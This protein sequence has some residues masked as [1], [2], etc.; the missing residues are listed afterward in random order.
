M[1]VDPVVTEE[2]GNTPDTPKADGKEQA[3]DGPDP[4]DQVA[5][6]QLSDG[7]DMPPTLFDEDAI[8]G[9][10]GD[11][12]M[13]GSAQGDLLIANDGDDHVDGQ[14]GND[15]LYG[16][17]GTDTL[18]GQGGDDVLYGEDGDDD[19]AGGDGD[20][21]L[22]GGDGD[23]LLR[24]GDGDDRL[25]G[26]LGQDTVL[27]G[28]GD[29][30]LDGT[31]VDVPGEGDADTGD[32]LW[33][34]AG[35]DTLAGGQGDTLTGGAGSDLYLF[36]APSA[37]VFGSDLTDAP[38]AD[39]QDA[40]LI[41]DFDRTEDMLE[42]VYDAAY[43]PAPGQMPTVQIAATVEAIEVRLN[44]A[45]VVRLSPGTEISEGDIQLVPAA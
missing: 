19:L 30:I 32:V 28:Q 11:N 35:N 34:E 31:Q 38:T 2:E 10:G 6:D 22:A 3:F 17:T 42:I 13:V 9:N 27:G 41:T 18:L 7:D 5:G 24:G 15:G 23:D 1:L 14:D 45:A 25:F 37:G 12:T 29:D 21:L 20:D 4:T 40:P 8:L 43:A 26:M 39:E 44:G 33:G 36:K 16:G